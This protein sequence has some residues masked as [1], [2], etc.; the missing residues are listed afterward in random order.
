MVLLFFGIVGGI[1]G[2][3]EVPIQ[4]QKISGILGGVFVLLGTLLFILPVSSPDNYTPPET[5]DSASDPPSPIVEQPILAEVDETK[6]ANNEDLPL[7]LATARQWPVLYK[8]SFDYVQGVWE[9]GTVESGVDEV[10]L[11]IS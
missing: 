2:K 9:I 5:G 4:R 3:V 10:Q 11:S 8:D 6:D 7:E 1:S